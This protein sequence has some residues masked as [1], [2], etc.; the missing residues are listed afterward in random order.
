MFLDGDILSECGDNL[1]V[2]IRK[3]SAN[4]SSERSPNDVHVERII[5][6]IKS[7]GYIY[8]QSLCTPNAVSSFR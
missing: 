4:V 3:R 7:K 5:A 1:V 8:V 6:Y 2:D